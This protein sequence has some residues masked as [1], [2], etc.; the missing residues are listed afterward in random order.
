MK[1]T[2]A[3]ALFWLCSEMLLAQFASHES[4][5]SMFVE[6][7]AKPARI[8]DLDETVELENDSLAQARKRRLLP[9]NISLIER[10]FWGESGVFRATGIAPLTPESRKEELE[11]RRIMLTS[12]QVAGIA[13]LGLM[14]AT[15]IVGQRYVDGDFTLYDTKRTLGNATTI[16]YM[17]TAAF[18]LFSPPP[19]V[20]RD[21]W[22]SISTHKLFALIHF[23]G[24][25]VT[26]LLANRIA[27]PNG[28][29]NQKVRLHQVA[30]Y[31]TTA[32]FSA[33]IISLAF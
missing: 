5:L 12:H 13:T 33:S 32:A 29:Y 19:A 15:V 16:A 17:T 2:L 21:E 4:R 18:S 25:I 28:D 26:P 31:I 30:S 22:N 3:F 11:V 1:P 20:R 9:K 10:A 27:S 7:E 24:M 14:I 23:T 6:Q 8:S